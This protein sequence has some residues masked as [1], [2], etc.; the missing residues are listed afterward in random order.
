[1]ATL[2]CSQKLIPEV[3]NTGRKN[4]RENN[5]QNQIAMER[6]FQADIMLVKPSKIGSLKSYTYYNHVPHGHRK[7]KTSCS[8]N[9]YGMKSP[10]KLI[11]KLKE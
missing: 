1:M 8:S 9:S 10:L 2:C 6:E 7:E 11:L 4:M 5:N 3:L